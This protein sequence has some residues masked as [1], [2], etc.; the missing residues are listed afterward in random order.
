SRGVTHIVKGAVV[1]DAT[2]RA[3]AD[4]QLWSIVQDD[5]GTTW[6]GTSS[7]LY[8]LKDGRVVH[9]TTQQGLASDIVYQVLPDAKGSVWV[10]GP[11][12]VSRL[13]QKELDNFAAGSRVE[14]TLHLDPYDLESAS[15]Y[16]GMQP[17]G[18][19]APNGEIW[20]ASNKGALAIDPRKVVPS[21]STPVEIEQVLVDGQP[22]DAGQMIR[23][24]PGNGRLEI[25]YG[26]IHL[27]SQGGVRY[28]YRMEG[29]DAWN[30][31]QT[32]RTAYYTHLPAGT[33]RFTVQATELD[34]PG[35]VT[36]RSITVIQ[37]PYFY[38]TTWFLVLC[39]IVLGGLVI[40]IYRLR[41]QQMRLRF[42]AVSDERARLAREMHDT[43]IQGCVGASTLLE[44]ALGIDGA[45]DEPL[46]QQLVSY[47]NDQMRST[48]DQAR[49]AVWALR[50]SSSSE[51]H[52]GILCG[53]IAQKMAPDADVPIRCRVTGTPYALSELATHE[54]MMAVR[55]AVLNAVSHAEA[56][57]IEVR[58]SFEEDGLAV[59]IRDDGRGFDVK[60][61]SAG[62]GH[63]G[64]VG[65]KERI[66]L[67]HGTLRI[68][69]AD[70]AGTTVR[71]NLPRAHRR[72]EP[73]K[74]GS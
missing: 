48:I 10:T 71:I 61:K 7:E 44:A 3:M 38:K 30:E 66:Q 73:V 13:R 16:S 25:S 31:A 54:L 19:V 29:L 47:A 56:Q 53:E 11:N 21:T 62:T 2:T 18:A 22:V 15:M 51:A 26:A 24:K 23:L 72:I 74:T 46:K 49:E 67:I 42:Q 27:R 17:E 41:L 4:E 68:E 63:Y 60:T 12:S 69:S 8:G 50:N 40:A 9:I 64:L 33:Y 70:G 5:A 14:M 52:V 6:F 45:A 65:M 39:G 59:E 28:R 20:L 34:Q 1:R 35:A 36:E 58:V 43:V 32:R 37:E 55:E 57:E